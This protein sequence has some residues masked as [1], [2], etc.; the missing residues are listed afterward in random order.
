M[1]FSWWKIL[2]YC[3]NFL[4][5][6]IGQ[7]KFSVYSFFFLVFFWGGPFF[8]V[9]IEFVTI[10]LLFHVLVFWPW[11]MWD[12]SSPTR[13]WTCTPCIARQSLNHWT[14]REVPSIYSWDNF[15]KL[16]FLRK[17]FF[18]GKYFLWKE[19]L[20]IFPK[21]SDL[22]VYSWW[23]YSLTFLIFILLISALSVPVFPFSY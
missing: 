13:D 4:S 22:L 5:N 12:P 21:F 17:I 6:Y 15:M 9:F 20:S 8:K 1:V 19:I 3:F 2:N 14:T 23:W 11:G 10:L 7:F 16:Y 18:L